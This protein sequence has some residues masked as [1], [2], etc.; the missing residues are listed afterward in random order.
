[1]AATAATAALSLISLA[2]ASASTTVPTSTTPSWSGYYLN[3]P[4]LTTYLGHRYQPRLDAAH[5]MFTVPAGQ[6]ARSAGSS[7]Y[8][9]GMWAGLEGMYSRGRDESL[10]QAGVVEVAGKKGQQYYLIFWEMYPFNE[11]QNFPGRAGPCQAGR[12]DRRLLANVIDVLAT[13][14][15]PRPPAA[16]GH[17]SRSAVVQGCAGRVRKIQ[18]FMSSRQ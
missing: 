12:Q 7:V 15:S 1:M 8:E 2:V 11:E 9:A 6:R 18:S 17:A 14:V 16:R 4:G 13:T 5:A 3:R 10:E